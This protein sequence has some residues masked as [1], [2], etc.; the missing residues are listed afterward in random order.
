M[1]QNTFY[2]KF[3]LSIKTAFLWMLIK[4]LY[5]FNKFTVEGENN[6]NALT[7]NNQSFILVS[8]HGKVLTVFH[9]S[10]IHI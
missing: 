1:Q 3:L 6:I 9:L 7:K 2:S 5:G 10:L 4:L 8:W